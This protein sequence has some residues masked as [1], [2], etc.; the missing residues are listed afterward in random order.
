MS[1]TAMI[2]QPARLDPRFQTT[3][4]VL[5]LGVVTL[6]V[7][8]I[9]FDRQSLWYDEIF[10]VLWSSRDLAFLIGEGTRIETNPPL[11]FVILHGWMQL[12]GNSAVAVRVPSLV[13]SILTVMATYALGRTLLDR[14]SALLGS[15]FLSLSAQSVDM[16]QEARPYAFVSLAAVIMLLASARFLQ[17]QEELGA[18]RGQKQLWLW[19]AIFVV[20]AVAVGW[21]HYTALLT[22]AA[23]FGVVYLK[24]AATRGLAQ[25]P[26]LIWG[27]AGIA[28][29][30]GVALPVLNAASLSG[31][32]NIAWI[33]SLTYRQLFVFIRGLLSGSVLPAGPFPTFLACVVVA[34]AIAGFLR[35]WSLFSPQG[36]ILVFAPVAFYAALVTVSVWKPML[37]PRYGTWLTIPFSLLLAT[38]AFGY[39]RHASRWLVAGS[40]A[41]H[42][43]ILLLQFLTVSREDWRAAAQDVG[44]NAAC[45]G[46][47]LTLNASGLGLVYYAPSTLNREFDQLPSEEAFKPTAQQFLMGQY[48]PVR[49]LLFEDLSEYVTLQRNFILIVRSKAEGDRVIAMMNA[50]AGRPNFEGDYGGNMRMICY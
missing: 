27:I 8:L 45:Q 50:R 3:R 47:V 18:R 34:F 22:V 26:L 14:R 7:R 2:A 19:A 49:N 16:A 24:L 10:S 35:Q 41:G 36:V 46:P 37:M 17:L 28:V 13:A 11:H 42:A 43:V 9:A 48:R 20:G 31:S 44:R 5:V 15:L 6:A 32:S 40:L 25:V 39:G 30:A 38:A 21:L 12:F 29:A 33:P 23:C 4:D 1:S